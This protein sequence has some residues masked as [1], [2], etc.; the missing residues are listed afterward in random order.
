MGILLNLR[1][2]THRHVSHLLDWAFIKLS[3]S[4]NYRTGHFELV[5]FL[6]GHCW[7]GHLLD[8]A[9]VHLRTLCT[10]SVR[11][12]PRVIVAVEAP[13]VVRLSAAEDSISF[14]CPL[15]PRMQRKRKIG[16]TDH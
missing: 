5:I 4:C 12:D 11:A 7:T 13:P 10:V 1:M 8:G 9:F 3:I 16:T 2:E 14:R 6:T 15:E